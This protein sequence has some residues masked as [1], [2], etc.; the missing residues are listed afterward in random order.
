MCYDPVGV[1]ERIT[2]L[3][4]VVFLRGNH[5]RYTIT[6]ERPGPTLEEAQVQPKLMPFLLALVRAVAT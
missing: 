4:N 2:S 1:L 5:D 6:G 3:P